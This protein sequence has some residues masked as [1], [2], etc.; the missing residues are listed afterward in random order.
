MMLSVQEARSSNFF[1]A[2]QAGKPGA[3]GGGGCIGEN[4]C[5]RST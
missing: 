2:F 1:E 4:D 5:G 3:A